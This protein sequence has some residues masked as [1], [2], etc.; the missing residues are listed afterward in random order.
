MSNTEKQTISIPDF[1]AAAKTHEAF[2]TDL[3]LTTD[4]NWVMHMVFADQYKHFATLTG[5]ISNM[6]DENPEIEDA[7]LTARRSVVVSCFLATTLIRLA[8]LEV[9]YAEIEN[10][11]TKGLP[12]LTYEG[13]TDVSVALAAASR[14]PVV[15][16][17]D[18]QKS[19]EASLAQIAQLSAFAFAN[20][21]DVEA[22]LYE[23]AVGLG[24]V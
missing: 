5:Q 8:Q 16:G 18:R 24:L 19:L 9:E 10:Y 11:I 1:M 17:E 7:M 21:V 15:F 23:V 12:C 2:S 6:E 13:D 4:I 3:S 20:H 22:D 14:F